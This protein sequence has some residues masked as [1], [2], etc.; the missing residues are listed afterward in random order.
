[1]AEDVQHQL[2]YMIPELRDLEERGIFN[3]IEIKSI[4]KR[5]TDFE[6]KL[7]RRISRKE[8]FLRYIEYEMN[9]ERLRI[10]RKERTKSLESNHKTSISDFSGVK[11]ITLLFEKMCK[12][13]H[14]DLE[15]WIEYIRF[16]KETKS[17]KIMNKVIAKAIQHHPREPVVWQMAASY[18]WEQNG[19]M[20]ASRSLFQRGLRFNNDSVEL[21]L[22]Y[23]KFEILFILKLLERRKALGISD[24]DEYKNQQS[25]FDGEIAKVVISGAL[26]CLKGEEEKKNKFKDESIKLFRDFGS[27]YSS[28]SET[29]NKLM[30][31]I[32]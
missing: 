23:L 9:L 18:E 6:Y 19:N 13:F 24:F 3:E 29:C 32:E 17:N 5:R 20:V 12:K 28:I 16:A 8:D 26:E 2:E 7:K 14:K 15:L 30:K 1:M 11:R 10:K 4:V 25:V 31:E 22:S 27:E 21:W